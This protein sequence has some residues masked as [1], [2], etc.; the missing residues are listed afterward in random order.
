[1]PRTRYT[2]QVKFWTTKGYG[3]IQVAGDQDDVFAHI[4]A[5]SGF[6]PQT[7]DKVSFALEPSNRGNQL[8]AVDVVRLTA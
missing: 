6:V 5:C 7:G 1:M 4:T 2:G 3:F 8:R